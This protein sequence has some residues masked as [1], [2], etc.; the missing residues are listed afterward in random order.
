MK[1][2]G[3]FSKI[4]LVFC[5]FMQVLLLLPHHH[6]SNGRMCVNPMHCMA[7][8]DGSCSKEDGCSSDSHWHDRED[9]SCNLV[10]FDMVRPERDK[11]PAFLVAM[12]DMG[13]MLLPILSLFDSGTL[14]ACASLWPVRYPQEVGFIAL[15]T[16]YII[17]AIP[18]RAPSFTVLQ[19]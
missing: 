17:S 5:I 12:T 10:H 6:H 14:E 19:A 18:P 7:A 1:K 2:S 8:H 3:L 9:S 16:D 15:H 4:V 13:D 11:T